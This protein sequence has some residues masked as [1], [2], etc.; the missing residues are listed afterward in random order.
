MARMARMC[1]CRTRMQPQ[2]KVTVRSACRPGWLPGLVPCRGE[3]VAHII[4]EVTDDGTPQLTSY[5]RIVLHVPAEPPS[6]R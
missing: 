1:R 4:L 6:A 3:G 5:R 2:A